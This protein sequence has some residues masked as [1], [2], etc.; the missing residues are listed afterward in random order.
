MGKVNM[1]YKRSS[2]ERMEIVF[3]QD[4]P[5]NGNLE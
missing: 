5:P 2:S 3:A 1:R 4:G